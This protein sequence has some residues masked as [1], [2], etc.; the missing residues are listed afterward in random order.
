VK[1]EPSWIS[2]SLAVAIHDRLLVEHGGAV[3][4]RDEG[5]LDSA[6]ASPQNRFHFGETDIILLAANYAYAISRSHPFTDGNK[7]T[8]FVVAATFLEMN[9][10]VFS[11]PESETFEK[12]LGLAARE[13]SETEFANWL[14]T[15]SRRRRRRN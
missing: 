4:F 13:V 11:A 15:N 3:G 7:R 1:R 6:L 14:K 8:A 5:S 2:K 10:F 12:V 9:G